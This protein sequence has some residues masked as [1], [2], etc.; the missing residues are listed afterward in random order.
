MDKPS[1]LEGL[2]KKTLN[3]SPKSERPPPSNSPEIARSVNHTEELSGEIFY[4]NVFYHPSIEGYMQHLH[5]TLEEAEKH[6]KSPHALAT[7]QVNH[8]PNTSKPPIIKTV[9]SKN[10]GMPNP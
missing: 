6:R 1:I 9:W 7:I 10:V 8:F 2:I 3:D 5:K 4:M